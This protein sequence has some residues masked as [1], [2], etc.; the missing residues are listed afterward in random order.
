MRRGELERCTIWDDPEQY[1]RTVATPIAAT[2]GISSPSASRCG[3]EKG[4]VR[5]VL[6]P[7]LDEFAVGFRVLH[8]FSGATTVYD[9]ARTMTAAR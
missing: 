7:V 9:V 3:R 4:T 1:A 8:G 2:S 6:A 5:G